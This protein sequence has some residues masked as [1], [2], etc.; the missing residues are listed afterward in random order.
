MSFSWIAARHW[1]VDLDDLVPA[2]GVIRSTLDGMIDFPFPEVA[3]APG[4]AAGVVCTTPDEERGS[5]CADAVD[6]AAGPPFLVEHS[7][8]ALVDGGI[9]ST[10]DGVKFFPFAD[11]PLDCI[12]AGFPF[13]VEHSVLAS[14]AGGGHSTSDGVKVVPFVGAPLERWEDFLCSAAPSAASLLPGLLLDVRGIV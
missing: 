10:S 1:R 11:A 8:P 4:L 13:L 3:L 12:A 9:H 7:V 14:A 2:T 5:P 6:G